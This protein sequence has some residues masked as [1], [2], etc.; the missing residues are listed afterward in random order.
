MG[1]IGAG[2]NSSVTPGGA[3]VFPTVTGINLEGEEKTIPRDLGG[4]LRVVCIAFE[5]QQ[6]EDVNT[7]LDKLTPEIL[8]EHNL[9]FYELPV[10][11]EASQAFR[12]WVNNGMRAG[13]RDVAARQRTITVY[14]DRDA[15]TSQLGLRLSSITT[16]L[17]DTHGTIVWRA[18]GRATDAALQ[19]LLA[20]AR[21]G[22]A[23]T[24][25]KT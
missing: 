9:H 11:Y 18:D 16:M 13:I 20:A 10:I 3:G 25:E 5:R 15:F 4:E 19:E 14:T 12:L 6:Q 17:L 2:A 24:S 8:A 23:P 1:C 21:S 7:W 22:G